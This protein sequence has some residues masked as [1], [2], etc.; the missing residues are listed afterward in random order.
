[1]Q[2]QT[3]TITT[4]NTTSFGANFQITTFE[5]T[6]SAFCDCCDNQATGAEETLKNQGWELNSSCQ[7]CPD[8]ND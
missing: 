7:F 5:Q 1:M 8:C 3:T 4:E 6:V 2:I